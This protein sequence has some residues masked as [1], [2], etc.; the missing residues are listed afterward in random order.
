MTLAGIGMASDANNYELASTGC[1]LAH[2]LLYYCSHAPGAA[3]HCYSAELVACS[4]TRN[5][6]RQRPCY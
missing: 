3:C 4:A 2:D 6:L 1:T 5:D